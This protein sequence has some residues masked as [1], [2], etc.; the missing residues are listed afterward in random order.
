M[1]CSVVLS[2]GSMS[3]LGGWK[4]EAVYP[5]KFRWLCFDTL[6]VPIVFPHFL[7]C[8]IF[9]SLVGVMEVKPTQQGLSYKNIFLSLGKRLWLN[10]KQQ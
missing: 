2:D 6:I 4:V 7:I 5:R 8:S 1:K 10:F 3:V 9:H